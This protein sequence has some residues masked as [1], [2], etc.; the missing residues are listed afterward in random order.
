MCVRARERESKRFMNLS[1]HREKHRSYA[2]FERRP[3]IVATAEIEIKIEPKQRMIVL[4]T[5]HCIDSSL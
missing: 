2:F 4:F 1:F 3:Y 5:L